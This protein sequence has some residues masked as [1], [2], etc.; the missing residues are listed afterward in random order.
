MAR[1]ACLTQPMRAHLLSGTAVT[2]FTINR[3]AEVLLSVIAVSRYL[4]MVFFILCLK[5]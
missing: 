3:N 5:S 2:N 1:D 4:A